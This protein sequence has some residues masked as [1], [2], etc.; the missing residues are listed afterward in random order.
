MGVENKTWVVLINRTPRGP[1]TEIE[2]RALLGQ[3]LIRTND[4]AYAVDEKGK[5]SD[6]KFL[7]Q[8][9]EFDRRLK[10]DARPVAEKRAP[11]PAPVLAKKLSDEIPEELKAILPED[12]VPRAR[13]DIQNEWMANRPNITEGLNDSSEPRTGAVWDN[14]RLVGAAA[15]TLVIA[16]LAGVF[17]GGGPSNE[18]V[19]PTAETTAAVRSTPG[20]RPPMGLPVQ[21]TITALPDSK[22]G[23]IQRRRP[24]KAAA[25]AKPAAAPQDRGDI[26]YDEYRKKRDEQ[27]EKERIAD[28][29][30]RREEEEGEEDQVDEEEGIKPMRRNKRK[31]ANVRRRALEQRDAESDAPDEDPDF[32]TEDSSSLEDE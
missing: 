17:L 10:Q 3:G 20:T 12:L 9:A 29:K 16:L 8:F 32:E 5:G 2:V 18:T 6:W 14:P 1:L 4:V 31:P 21:R 25:A 24:S 7:W 27:I 19:T 15:G 11:T 28:E 13:Q 26:S 23:P 30:R 22:P